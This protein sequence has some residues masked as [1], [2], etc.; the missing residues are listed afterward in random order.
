MYVGTQVRLLQGVGESSG[1][2]LVNSQANRACEVSHDWLRGGNAADA[3][4][5]DVHGQELFACHLREDDALGTPTARTPGCLREGFTEAK[6]TTADDLVACFIESIDARDLV[7]LALQQ[8]PDSLRTPLAAA[9]LAVFIGEETAGYRLLAD[10][11]ADS[12]GRDFPLTP[13]AAVARGNHGSISPRAHVMG[14]VRV[15]VAVA[16]GGSAQWALRFADV[17]LVLLLGFLVTL[18]VVGWAHA[19]IL[20]VPQEDLER[21]AENVR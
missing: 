17:M 2:S 19:A 20:R 6:S 4:E 21:E 15:V 13:E 5:T 8:L 10:L 18:T 11:A 9:S 3:C 1:R 7:E 12:N 16:T 14:K